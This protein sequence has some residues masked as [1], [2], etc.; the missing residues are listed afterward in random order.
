MPAFPQT[1]IEFLRLPI[2]PPKAEPHPSLEKRPL[3]LGFCSR[4][5]IEQKRVDLLPKLSVELDRLGINYRMEFLGDGLDRELL[6]SF[7]CDRSRSTFH[8]VKSGADYW[9]ILNGW[10]A[11]ISVSDYEGT[12][13][14]L[15]EAL[16]MGVV[17]IFPAIGSG[18]DLYVREV[19]SNFI[20]SKGD[21]SA[22]AQSI[23]SLT[24]SAF[25][26]NGNMAARGDKIG[27]SAI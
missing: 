26:T 9:K 7:F 18:G 22:A 8:G 4:L 3:I 19:S 12:P 25:R 20:F 16:A 1:R 17:P 21:M 27:G 10:D 24:R 13:I 5:T 23:L 2:A 15:L 14:A 6:E 11:L